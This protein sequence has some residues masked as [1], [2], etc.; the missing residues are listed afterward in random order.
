MRE[1]LISL[2]DIQ[3]WVDEVPDNTANRDFREDKGISKNPS[4]GSG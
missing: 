3:S 1:W 2:D 4:T